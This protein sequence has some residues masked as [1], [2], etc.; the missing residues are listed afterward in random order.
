VQDEL[1]SRRIGLIGI[2][3]DP[4]EVLA[5]FAESKQIHFPLL[6]DVGSRVIAEVGLLDRDL[7]EHHAAFG[8]QTR[9][10]QIGVA[11]PA[12]FVLD[13]TGRIVD[14]RIGEN[15]RIREGA[16]KLL[17]EAVGVSLPPSGERR[18]EVG[19][20]VQVT[21]V[22]DAATYSRFQPTRLHVI[23]EIDPGWHVYGRP[24]PDGYQPLT[25]EVEP[26]PGLELGP[27]TYP[28]SHPFRLEGVDEEFKAYEV[29][30]E[31]VVPFAVQVSAGHGPIELSVHIQ[32][33]TCST[34]EC[35]PPSV[36]TLALHLDE[37][38]A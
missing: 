26:R 3:Y 28:Q 14:K 24:I 17:D 16:L 23:I 15:Y 12:V 27:A 8:I 36:V 30:C 33:Q 19:P 21:A 29:R 22:S 13:K 6:S 37:A 11:Y 2:S 10:F 38:A 34:S 32:Y 4:P 18:I 5:T 31:V 20:H 1:E 9:D 35:L 25:V 7:V